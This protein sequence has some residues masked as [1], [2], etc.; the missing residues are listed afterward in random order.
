MHGDTILLMTFVLALVA[1]FAGGMVARALRLPPIV[2]YLLGGLVVG[3]FTPGFAGDSHAMN[4]LAEVG[5]MFMMFG[6]GLHFSFKD[7]LE[8]KG[9]ADLTEYNY[10]QPLRYTVTLDADGE[11]V[12]DVEP[13]EQSTMGYV[14]ELSLFEGKSYKEIASLT[15]LGTDAELSATRTNTALREMILECFDAMEEVR[16]G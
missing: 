7:L 6:T 5:V 1:A 13:I 14:A 16:N 12:T 4:Q 2:G 15:Q 11:F 9:I 8:V 3:P 10:Q